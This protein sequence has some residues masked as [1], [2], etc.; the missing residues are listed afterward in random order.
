MIWIKADQFE[1]TESE[2]RFCYPLPNHETYELL[3]DGWQRSVTH[4]YTPAHIKTHGHLR[5]C[6]RRNTHT[7]THIHT[8]A[9]THRYTDK[10]TQAHRQRVTRRH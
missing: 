6:T 2:K 4:T 3:V 1:G 5:I 10:D 8:D 7:Q 9:Q